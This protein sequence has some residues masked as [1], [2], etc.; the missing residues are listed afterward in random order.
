MSS[1]KVDALIVQGSLQNKELFDLAI[2][3]QLPSFSS[4][5]QVARSGGLMSYAASRAKMYREMARYVD[6]LFGRG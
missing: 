3:Y 1:K 5:T 4:N 6:K 2:K